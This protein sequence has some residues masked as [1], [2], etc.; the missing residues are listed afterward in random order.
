MREGLTVTFDMFMLKVLN[1]SFAVWFG[2]CVFCF[3]VAL[4][5]FDLSLRCATRI[6]KIE[7]F[8]TCKGHSTNM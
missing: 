3:N 7:M 5:C 2:V 4:I 8:A 1:K 6:L